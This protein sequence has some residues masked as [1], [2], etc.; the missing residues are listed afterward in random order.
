[1]SGPRDV[2][3]VP[4]LGADRAAGPDLDTPLAE[5]VVSASQPLDDVSE[6][7]VR[8]ARPAEDLGNERLVAARLS[9]E[10]GLGPPSPLQK[11]AQSAPRVDVHPTQHDKGLGT[12]QDL[13]HRSSDDTRLV[14]RVPGTGPTL[15]QR[16]FRVWLAAVEG[17]IG[18]GWQTAL[19]AKLGVHQTMISKIAGGEREAG[20]ELIEAAIDRAGVSRD[21]FF[22]RALGEKPAIDVVVSNG[23]I[24]MVVE[25]KTLR[26]GYPEVERY[27]ADMD[28]AGTPVSAEHA[29]EL[30]EIR[31]SRGPDGVDRERVIGWHRGMIASDARRAFDS[32]IIRTQIQSARGQR[33]LPPTK[34][35]SRG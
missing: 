4:V 8:L 27:I 22:D 31:L 19:A 1:M 32:P 21:F 33:P 34:R 15:A 16:R 6:V 29:R 25:A 28:A 11:R 18:K 2:G 23:D 7:K 12:R 35:K 5:V 26:G 9:S 17:E 10:V 3:R 30:R 20:I 24:R 13:C 14:T